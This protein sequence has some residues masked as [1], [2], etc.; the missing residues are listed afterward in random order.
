M[1]IARAL[2]ARP[3]LWALACAS[4]L[5]AVLWIATLAHLQ[6]AHE[7]YAQ[8]TQRNL[9]TIARSLHAH[10]LKTLQLA[11]QAATFIQLDYDVN[12]KDMDL[13]QLVQHRA[14]SEDM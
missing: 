3:R 6:L 1:T 9:L 12:G 10:A 5:T 13:Q 4:A 11:D 7:I 2:L 8:S 14:L